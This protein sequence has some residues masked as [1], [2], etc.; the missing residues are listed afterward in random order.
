MGQGRRAGE[1][2]AGEGAV[3][4]GRCPRRVAAGQTLPVW[5]PVQ[6]Q[7]V[8]LLHP[9]LRGAGGALPSPLRPPLP[10]ED[11]PRAAWGRHCPRA[12]QRLCRAGV[13]QRNRAIS[14]VPGPW[15]R[16]RAR[17]GWSSPRGCAVGAL[18]GTVLTGRATP[19]RHQGAMS[20]FHVATVI[21]HL[22][23]AKDEKGRL[24]RP[25]VCSALQ[26]APGGTGQ[27]AGSPSSST[28]AGH[29]PR[30]RPGGRSHLSGR[31]APS[32]LPPRHLQ[33]WCLEVRGKLGTPKGR[34]VTPGPARALLSFHLL[35]NEPQLL[36]K[37]FPSPQE[38]KH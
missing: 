15:W 32:L 28:A 11:G 30:A 7:R 21:H 29:P 9:R 16:L 25:H 22:H 37:S 34:R 13:M 23:V 24:T 2:G 20:H 10:H 14:G 38:Q 4:P 5:G 18:R 36:G 1:A 3:T 31:G 12:G 33:G 8:G 6:T 17:L 35:S 19:Q 27:D 26:G